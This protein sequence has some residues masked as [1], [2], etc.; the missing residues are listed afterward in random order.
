MFGEVAIEFKSKL[1]SVEDIYAIA[2]EIFH[3]LNK[4]VDRGL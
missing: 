4:C 1:K 3:Y 2:I